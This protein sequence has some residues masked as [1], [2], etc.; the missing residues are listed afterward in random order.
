M[1]N[2][3]TIEGCEGVGKSTQLKLL[4]QFCQTNKYTNIM[5]TREPGGSVISEAIRNIILNPKFTQMTYLTEAMLYAAARAQ[6]LEEKVKP[7]LK[8]GYTVICDR[9]VDSSYAYQGI[10]RGLGLQLVKD[11]NAIAI[12]EYMPQYT[13]FLDLNPRAAF[14]RKGGADL[15]DRLETEDFSFYETVYEGYKRIIAEDP[16][17]FIIIDASGD[18]GHTLNLII[19]ELKYRGVL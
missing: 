15:K 14:A 18:A 1:R 12:G 6:H 4:S 3:I 5:F 13:I 19:N 7:S 11:L 2:F 8:D 16:K 10:A 9:F 17:R